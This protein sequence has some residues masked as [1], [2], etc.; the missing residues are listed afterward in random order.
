MHNAD[1]VVGPCCSIGRSF[2]RWV[3][4]VLNLL[5]NT[6]IVDLTAT[7]S[8]N[9]TYPYLPKPKGALHGFVAWER[10]AQF[11]RKRSQSPK[12]RK[13]DS[14]PSV[15]DNINLTM[16]SGDLRARKKQRC[17]YLV[18]HESIH[19]NKTSASS[20]STSPAS[21]P[22]LDARA[23]FELDGSDELEDPLLSIISSCSIDR[24]DREHFS[25]LSSAWSAQERLRSNV[26]DEW[27]EKESWTRDVWMGKISLDE[28]DATEWLKNCGAEFPEAEC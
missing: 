5:A 27:K 2:R 12:K 19:L 15:D 16:E 20:T 23:S 10:C 24:Q 28:E 3:A 17:Q 26:H 4:E 14:M 18:P 11:S 1:V 21:L 25:S 7:Q 13:P 22:E 6:L 9:E 8:I